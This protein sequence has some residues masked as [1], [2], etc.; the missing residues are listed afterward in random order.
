MSLDFP[1]KLAEGKLPRS[2]AEQLAECFTRAWD[3][4]VV[5]TV[6]EVHRNRRPNKRKYYFGVVVAKVCAALR[7]A[8]NSMDDEET[9]T[10]LK[11]EV[12]KLKKA[13][14]LPTGEI[15]YTL[16]S[17]MDLT[18]REESDYITACV[19]WCAEMGIDIPPPD[20]YHST[21]KEPTHD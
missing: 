13:V 9:H 5:I 1:C 12:G 15:K 17:Y 8:G 19:A 7:E 14:I 4:S 20:I 2:V 6:K 18:P 11:R 16:R 3:K 21:H 10:F